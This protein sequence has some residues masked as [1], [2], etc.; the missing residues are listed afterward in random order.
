MS[1]GIEIDLRMVVT[2]DKEMDQK[3]SELR[4]VGLT[5]QITNQMTVMMTEKS[6]AWSTPCKGENKEASLSELGSSPKV[7]F[8]HYKVVR[9]VREVV[10]H[11]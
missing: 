1:E 10:A 9:V 3:G 11:L 8:N 7:V 2:E 6:P 4:E 5:D